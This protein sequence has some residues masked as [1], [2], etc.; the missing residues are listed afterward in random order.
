MRSWL[1]MSRYGMIYDK[2]RI[3]KWSGTSKL[4]EKNSD[5]TECVTFQIA[6]LLTWSNFCNKYRKH[7]HTHTYIYL[8]MEGT[9]QNSNSYYFRRWN[10]TIAGFKGFGFFC[11]V[12]SLCFGIKQGLH[13]IFRF[14]ISQ[15]FSAQ[16]I[17]WF[18]H[19]ALKFIK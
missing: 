2:L 9:H 4:S 3:L 19:I 13:M 15:L 12:L 5:Q 6:K 8:H 11:F 7:P 14:T 1:A 10:V 18:S 17:L 16:I